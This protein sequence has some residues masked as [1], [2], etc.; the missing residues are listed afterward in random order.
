MRRL[1]TLAVLL[2]LLIAGAGLTTQLLSNNGSAGLP[3]LPQV[4]SPEASTAAVVPWKA[5]QLFLL[6][7]FIVSSLVVFALLL[8]VVFWFLDRG[9]KRARAEAVA[10]GNSQGTGGTTP[11]NTSTTRQIATS[12]V[13]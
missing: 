1:I 12:T 9:V 10:Q 8:A 7:G 6:V 4:G 2:I 3:I 11:P 13:E 5:E